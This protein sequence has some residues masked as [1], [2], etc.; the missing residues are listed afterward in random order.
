M[1]MEK[2]EFLKGTGA[3]SLLLMMGI[4][5]ESCS[6]EADPVPKN[7]DPVSI[8]LNDPQYSVLQNENGWVLLT[9]ERVLLVNVS[10]EIVALSSVCT[11]QGCS[12]DWQFISQ[13]FKEGRLTL[14]YKI[15]L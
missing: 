9:K 15:V 7:K 13:E 8:D 11:H 1:N 2:R 10:G 14:G 6:S 5:L 12:T 3:A 4:H